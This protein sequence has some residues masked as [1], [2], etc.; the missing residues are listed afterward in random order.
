MTAGG[1][2]DVLAV[3]DAF[4]AQGGQVCCGMYQGGGMD[5]NGN[6]EPPSCCGQPFDTDDLKKARRQIAELIEAVGDVYLPDGDPDEIDCDSS[7]MS[8]RII[9]AIDAVRAS[10][11]AALVQP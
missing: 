8:C 7:C 4:A 11:L 1:G 6:G 9:R 10:A 5:E 3:L 2:V